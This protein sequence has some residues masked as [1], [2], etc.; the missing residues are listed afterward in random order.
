MGALKLSYSHNT[1]EQGESRFAYMKVVYKNPTPSE[2]HGDYQ[3]CCW[4]L[5]P[6]KL[7]LT[8]LGV[9]LF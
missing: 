4:F 6:S 2:P 3:L 5:R 7:P 9:Y 8:V 1:Y